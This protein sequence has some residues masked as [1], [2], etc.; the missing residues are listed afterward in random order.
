MD[1]ELLAAF[2]DEHPDQ[3]KGF[4]AWLSSVTQ[5]AGGGNLANMLTDQVFIRSLFFNGSKAGKIGRSKY[6]MIKTYLSFAFEYYGLD[7]KNIPPLNALL[8]EAPAEEAYF[9]SFQDLVDHIDNIGEQSIAGYEK[10]IGLLKIK[11]VVALGWCGVPQSVVQRVRKQDVKLLN[12]GSAT[13]EIKAVGRF[14]LCKDVMPVI[15]TLMSTTS[16][17]EWEGIKLTTEK[18]G[19][20]LIQKTYAVQ[21]V[22]GV[23]AAT[24]LATFEA[25]AR[26]VSL[27]TKTIN[28]RNLKINALF[29]A[30]QR[31]NRPMKLRDKFVAN[32]RDCGVS[33]AYIR[34]ELLSNYKAWLE[35]LT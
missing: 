25:K 7:K 24:A 6:Y 5:L 8:L 15:N 12:D 18:G 31:D 1:N 29:V 19:I 27:I 35:K 32:A 22:S 17:Q 10:A 3:E 34:P 11:G 2:I 20:Y 33:E 30:V 26:K 14:K 28:Y 9:K 21:D 16:Y 13:L 23:N 4:A